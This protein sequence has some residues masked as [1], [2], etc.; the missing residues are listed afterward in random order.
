MP[1][2]S[3]AIRWRAIINAMTWQHCHQRRIASIEKIVQS[4]MRTT[5]AM[6][7]MSMT[8]LS[9]PS[10]YAWYNVRK[11]RNV[12]DARNDCRGINGYLDRNRLAY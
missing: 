12:D 9:P 4:A 1:R 10:D 5:I 3:A 2:I 11:E 7:S 6:V 8:L